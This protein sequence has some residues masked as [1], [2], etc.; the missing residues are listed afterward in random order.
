[1]KKLLLFA[2]II[3]PST[4][5]SQTVSGLKVETA[6]GS[7]STVTFDVE[8]TAA[9][10]PTP[11]LDSMW[12]FVDYNKNGRME[13]LLISGGTLTEHTAT[14][15]GTGIFIPENDMG[16]WVYG[17]A[18]TS[19][20]GSFS[21]KVQLYTKETDIIIAGA[22][23]YASSYPPVGDWIDDTRIGFTGTPWYEIT[24]TPEG[25][26]ADE[27]VK[28]GSTFLLPCSYTVSSFT[29]KTGAPG[30]F[31]C[32]RPATYTLSG[33][34]VCEGGEVT[35]TLD[36]S[37]SE[38]KYQ[39]HDGNAL[40]GS[41]KDG[42]GGALIF[43]DTPAS[44]GGY[45]YTVR[46]VG[47][48]GARCDMPVSNVLNV[49]VNPTPANL[50][51]T[52]SST[53]VCTYQLVILTAL[54]AGAASYS[55]DGSAWQS[56]NIFS[57][58]PSANSSYT[59]YVQT[60]AGC[61][62]TK[63]DAAMVAINP[64]PNVNSSNG[65][66]R[67]GNGSVTLTATPSTGVIDWYEASTGGSVLSGGSATNSFITPTLGGPKSYYAQARIVATG[68]V[69]TARTAVT[70]TINSIPDPPIMSGG[71]THCYSANIT[72]T[73]GANGAGIMWTDNGAPGSTSSSR[74]EYN[75]GAY[76][77]SAVSTSDK[78]CANSSVAS[79]SFTI[80]QGSGIGEAV[81]ECGCSSGRD[82]SGFCQECCGCTSWPNNNCGITAVSSAPAEPW[83][84]WNAA[85]DL[86]NSRGMRL[87]TEAELVCMCQ[88][89]STIPGGV[90]ANRTYWGSDWI[91]SDSG[92]AYVYVY[93]SNCNVAH[94]VVMQAHNIKC[95]KR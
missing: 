18:R 53:T 65:A 25:G 1:M 72:A 83:D 49:T 80:F 64:V 21:A 46:T 3:L 90:E 26:G 56:S 66:S 42:T 68:C 92:R 84:W 17:D 44:A 31:K 78:G 76:T 71:G 23:A 81:N 82:C 88:N 13:R 24:L 95:V 77:Y 4:L 45:S 52:A 39:L 73:P 8:W 79:V 57:R 85:R 29:D 67:C 63:T 37:E 61:T 48:A 86:C 36:G 9:T 33:A 12:V 51:L 2:M 59:L 54:P 43:K 93:M 14:K 28:S 75:P 19:A 69:S 38:W 74:Y 89:A 55:I 35:L 16:A 94:G 27:T 30:I 40:V 11:W 10:L 15:A 5:L 70:A 6:S 47:G 87:P 41:P 20:A 32:I 62:A 34:D 22:C 58:S 91:A 60:A 50:S 7:A